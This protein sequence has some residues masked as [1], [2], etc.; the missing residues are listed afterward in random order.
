[1]TDDENFAKRANKKD[2]S[3]AEGESDSL[4]HES[5]D[6]L[7]EEEWDEECDGE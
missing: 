7:V 6:N 5:T 1:M 3:I 2:F 4:S